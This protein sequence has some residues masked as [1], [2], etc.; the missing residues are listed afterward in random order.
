M[1][2]PRAPI[3]RPNVLSRV[4]RYCAWAAGMVAATLFASVAH[5]QLSPITTCDN[6]GIGSVMLTADG[7][8]VSILDVS[9]GTAG[10]GATAVPY[11]LVKVRVPTAINIWVGLPMAGKWNG[12]LQSQGGG[13]YAG[14]VGV[15]TNSILGGYVGITTDTGH[16][17]G[18][19]SFGMLAQGS[20]TR[21]S[22]STSPTVP[23]I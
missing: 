11:C 3:G 21:C 22:R 23:S 6:A 7:P 20:P 19:G 8:P 2:P 12:R 4:G 18:D 10:S 9:T 13:G 14:S 5:A 17:G 15:P 1:K 16:T